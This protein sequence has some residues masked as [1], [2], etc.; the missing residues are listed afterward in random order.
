MTGTLDPALHLLA[1]LVVAGVL[2]SAAAHKLR[3]PARF[4]AALAGYALLP[5]RA[6]RP[7]AA[8]L[9]GLELAL[10]GLLLAPGPGAGPALGSAALLALYAGA[11]AANLARGRRAIDCGCGARPQPLGAGLVLRNALL[12]ALA[13]AAALPAGGRALS[14]TDAVTLAGGAAALWLLHAA[15]GAALANA[16]HLRALRSRA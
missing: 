8:A 4:R 15:A 10:G 7:A 5:V 2:L 13:L 9:V 16:A 1:R 14:F 11:I 12:V 3:D 6:L